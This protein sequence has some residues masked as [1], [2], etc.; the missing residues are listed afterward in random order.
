[1]KILSLRTKNYRTLENANLEFPSAYTAICGPNDSG[2]T[3]V[4][5]AIRALMR[6]DR[7]LPFEFESDSDGV[8]IKD[9]Y[10]KWLETDPTKR[11]VSVGISLQIERDRDTALFEFYKKHLDLDSDE[12]SLVIDIDALYSA[13]QVAPKVVVRCHGRRY[14]ELSAQEALKRLQNSK[15]V[16]FHNSTQQDAEAAMRRHF[17]GFVRELS[18]ADEAE[19]SRMKKTVNKGLA[20]IAK[21]RQTEIEDLLGRLETKYRVSLSIPAFDFN[22]M[23]FSITLGQKKYEVPLDEWGSGTQNRTMILMT[24]FRAKQIAETETTTS[25]ITPVIVVEEPESFLHPSAQAEFGRVLQDLAEEFQVQVIVTTHS[26]YML[27]MST[28]GANLLLRRKSQYRQ[29]RETEC[30]DSNGDN[31]MEP[32]GLALGLNTAEFAAWRDVF[33]SDSDTLIL[34]EGPTDKRYFELLAGEHLGDRRL[35]ITGDIVAYDGMGSLKSQVLLKFIL[36]RV[37]KVIV[38]CDLDV[39]DQVQGSLAALGLQKNRDFFAVG[40]DENGKRCIEGLLPESVTVE[41]YTKNPGLVQAA[42]S[43]NKSEKESAQSN[44]K[45]KLLEE[46]ERQ[47]AQDKRCFAAFIP[48]VESLNKALSR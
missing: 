34:V 10:P 28:P 9:D 42:M 32:F 30:I 4:V 19:I 5:R 24:L 39:L 25:K 38:T 31:W 16:L 6:E 3:N 8:S 22:Y 11:E 40:L 15:S 21:G 45:Q 47:C 29:L 20:K 1:M 46:F 27:S 48:L 18:R 37:K 33:R 26:P 7:H 12:G 36:S 41:V 13:E 14:E 35:K 44:L 23:P 43:G 17:G 2:K